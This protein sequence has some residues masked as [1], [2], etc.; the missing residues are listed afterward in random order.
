MKKMKGV[1]VL[2]VLLIG[3][4]SATA[5]A[6][7]AD[8][9]A[10]VDFNSAYVWRGLTFNDGFVVQPYLDVTKGGFGLNVWSNY[11]VDDYDGAVESGEF[12]EVDLTASYGFA[13]GELD[14]GIGYIEYLFPAGGAGTR[15]VYFSLGTGVTEAFSVGFDLYYD[16]DE[17]DDFYSALSCSYDIAL[18]DKASLGF[19]AS[20]GFAGDEYCADGDAG[21]FDYSL[22]ASYGYEIDESWSIGLGVTYV[23]PFDEDKLVDDVNTYGTF[24]IGY[25]F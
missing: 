7:D 9:S 22:S 8:V 1:I 18:D 6:S 5:W 13:I 19:G 12:S 14:A 21:L 2:A 20:M 4:V 15:E 16:F 24:S 11:D 25:A 17:V 3:L 23:A 10:G